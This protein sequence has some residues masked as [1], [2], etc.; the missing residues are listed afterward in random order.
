MTGIKADYA[1]YFEEPLVER[2][3]K[4]RKVSMKFTIIQVGLCFN[5]RVSK[6]E[7]EYYPFTFYLFPGEED[8][9]IGMQVGAV[10][11]NTQNNMDWNRWI[12]KGI[13]Y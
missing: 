7:F 9:V 10:K 1:D 4:L 5:I 12:G 6:D 8:R 2:Y 13:N 3:L 11:F